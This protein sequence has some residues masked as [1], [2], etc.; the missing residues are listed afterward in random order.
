MLGGL[1]A[2]SAIAEPWAPPG[3]LGLR[4]DLQLL[5]DSGA[6]NLPLTTWPL[7]WSDIAA[8]LSNVNS[9]A[10]A[11]VAQIA[12]ARLNERLRRETGNKEM[13]YQISAAAAV[14]PR[15]IRS[16]ENT[17]REE[18]GLS[19]GLSWQGERFALNLNAT[20][21]ANPFDDDEIRPDGSYLGL[22]LGN[23]LLSVGWQERWWGPGR[24]GSLI[25]GSNARPSPGLAIQRNRSTPFETRWLGWIGPWTL[26]TFMNQLDDER[27]VNDALLFGMRVTLRPINSLEIGLSRTAQWCGDD[28]PCGFDAF[29][30]LLLGNDN[31]GVNVDPDDEPGNQLAGIDMRWVLPKSLPVA[32]YMQ[33][34]GEDTRRGGP[35]LGSWLRQVGIEHWGFL[36]SLSHRTHLELSDTTCREG[37]FGFSDLKPNCA[38]EHSIYQTGYRYNGRSMAYGTDGDGLTWSLGSTLVESAGHSWNL[39]V[40]HME[41]NRAGTPDARH[42]LTAT[43][44]DLSDLQISHNRLIRFGRL[45]VG[46]GVSRLE[47]ES[48]GDSTNDVFGFVEW[49]T[50]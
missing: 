29:T 7:S 44:Q 1:L 25:L 46:I 14:E 8:G 15:M 47:D 24:D 5:N 48:S 22:T 13:H 45:Y 18:G 26:T 3:D 11:P 27:F 49:A 23:W 19:G 37:G 50:E 9:G 20:L 12:Y 32:L 16:F 28:R 36:G 38:Y 39:T 42:T 4:H 17:P 2:Q 21:A 31:R 10:L 34:I 41:L 30:D 6:T 33:W 43:P 35:E 40:R